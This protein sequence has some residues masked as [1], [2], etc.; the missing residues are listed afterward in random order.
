[1]VLNQVGQQKGPANC[2]PPKV[3]EVS[4]RLRQYFFKGYVTECKGWLMGFGGIAYWASSFQES[5]LTF[6]EILPPGCFFHDGE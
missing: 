3:I 2:C 4:P 5:L 1:M 6:L